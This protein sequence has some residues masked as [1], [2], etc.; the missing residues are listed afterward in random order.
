[1]FKNLPKIFVAVGLVNF[2]VFISPLSGKGFGADIE[3]SNLIE[4]GNFMNSGAWEMDKAAIVPRH[5]DQEKKCVKLEPGASLK[6]SVNVEGGNVYRISCLK[7]GG[8]HWI[9]VLFYDSAGKIIPGR[10]YAGDTRGDYYFPFAAASSGW[11]Q[12]VQRLLAPKESA[13]LRI[14]VSPMAKADGVLYLTEFKVEKDSLIKS[15]QTVKANLVFHESFDGFPEVEANGGRFRPGQTQVDFVPGFKGNAA[16]FSNQSGIYYSLKGIL[17]RFDEGSVEM[18]AKIAWPEIP[19]NPYHPMNLWATAFRFQ[20]ETDR[21]ELQ[22]RNKSVFFRIAG[23]SRGQFSYDTPELKGWHHLA[24]SWKANQGKG[25]DFARL[26]LDG[27]LLYKIDD[28][29]INFIPGDSDK[30]GF[31]IGDGPGNCI[32]LIDELKIYNIAREYSTEEMK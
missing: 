4:N 6:Q 9:H 27:K 10:G 16:Q 30:A 22:F 7:Y 25:L 31:I 1:M 13:Q 17:E 12:N 18:Y 28:F 32:C 3:R 21:L 5:D 19:L 14:A 24:F 29:P 2:A 11:T 23:E 8:A 15:M 20:G 26:Y